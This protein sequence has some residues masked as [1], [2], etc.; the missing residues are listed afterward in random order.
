MEVKL[1]TGA[2]C[3]LLLVAAGSIIFGL[4]VRAEVRVEG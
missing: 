2:K 1:E 3:K 4:E